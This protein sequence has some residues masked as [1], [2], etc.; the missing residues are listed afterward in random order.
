VFWRGI[1]FSQ[2]SDGST[3]DR[4]LISYGGGSA[5]TGNVNFQMGSVVTIGAVTFTH[6]EDYAAVIYAGSAPMFTGPP[7][8]RVYMFNGQASNP[9]AGDPLFDCVRDVA[10]GNCIRP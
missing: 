3:L 6:S 10:A 7:T 1:E 9:G 4:V 2:G 5:N 8:D